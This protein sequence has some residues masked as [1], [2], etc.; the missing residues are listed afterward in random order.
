ML[1][2]KK[3]K[4]DHGLGPRYGRT[5]RKRRFE[6]EADLRKRHRCQK[7]GAKAVKRVSVGVWKCSKCG[8]TTS[9]GAYSPSSKI[10]EV[11]KRSVETLTTE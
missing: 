11:A 10:G 3:R 8:V 6:V 5:V 1:R 9:G 7:C 4:T 2:T